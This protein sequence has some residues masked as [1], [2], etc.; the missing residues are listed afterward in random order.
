[1]KKIIFYLKNLLSL[2]VAEAKGVLLMLL[3]IAFFIG[4]MFLSDYWF[5]KKTQ[6]LLIYS[7][8]MLDSMTVIVEKQSNFRTFDNKQSN[9][10]YS[11]VASKKYRLF[12]FNPNELNVSEFQEL[13]LPKFLA[14][15]I[16]NFRNKG[17]K[18]R[19]KE[20]L[21]KIYGLSPEK[22]EELEPFIRLPT[23]DLEGKNIIQEER[24]TLN[25]PKEVIAIK[26]DFKV[27]QKFD[28]NLADTSALKKLKGIGSGF[29]KRIVKYRDLLGGFINLEQIREVYGLP[30]ET[31]DEIIKNAFIQK[32]PKLLNINILDANSLRHPYLKSFQ[33]KSIVAYREQ[34]GLYKNISD[35]KALKTL[36]EETILKIQPYLEF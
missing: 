32:K 27:I 11:S 14:E 1:M 7:P 15:R 23:Q 6:N 10:H 33:V 20:D 22:Y 16:I 25:P 28:L 36:D 34:H 5:G 12:N 13:G 9:N 2:S 21:S 29:A 24:V 17:G 35:L 19:N 3:L 8:K 31:A 30:T 4:A 26:N 18:F